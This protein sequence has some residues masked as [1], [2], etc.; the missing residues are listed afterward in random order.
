MDTFNETVV[1]V[2]ANHAEMCRFASQNDVGYK[3]VADLIEEFASNAVD[4]IRQGTASRTTMSTHGTSAEE[5]LLIEP[6]GEEEQF[7]ASRS[8]QWYGNNTRV[9]EPM[10]A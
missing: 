2:P 10:D 6:A 4:P 3:R 5:I 1:T 7:V 9:E 8:G